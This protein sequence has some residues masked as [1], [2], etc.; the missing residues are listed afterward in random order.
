M[1]ILGYH[2][3][4]GRVFTS[5]GEDNGQ[6]SVLKFLVRK[7]PNTIRIVYDL[8][9]SVSSLLSYLGCSTSQRR[10]LLDTTKLYL[11]PYH[12]RYVPSKFMSLKTPSSFS[13][14]SNA[15]QYVDLPEPIRYSGQD[16]KYLVCKAQEIGER[17]YDILRDLGIETTSLTNPARAYE[18]TGFV[19][20]M[21]IEAQVSFLDSRRTKDSLRNSIIDRIVNSLKERQKCGEFV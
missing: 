3:D 20:F 18:K 6:I 16:P 4:R 17:V 1:R 9:Y 19:G 15:A 11:A 12:I 10:D 14:Y 8:G 21:S 2:I 5:D 13:Y 7:Y